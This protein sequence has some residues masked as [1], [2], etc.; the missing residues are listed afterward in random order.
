MPADSNARQRRAPKLLIPNSNVK[1]YRS[2]NF[3]LKSWGD[4]C[5]KAYPLLAWLSPAAR[6]RERR[7]LDSS[8]PYAKYDDIPVGSVLSVEWMPVTA[9]SESNFSRRAQAPYGHLWGF[10]PRTGSCVDSDFDASPGKSGMASGC[11]RNTGS[12]RFICR[13]SVL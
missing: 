1:W 7:R 4:F 8:Y 12:A 5:E 2:A 9:E 6:R 11:D 10:H 13:A 3:V